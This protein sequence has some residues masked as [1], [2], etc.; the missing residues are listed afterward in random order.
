MRDGLEHQ[1]YLGDGVYAGWDGYHVILWLLEASYLGPHTIALEPLTLAALKLY[2]EE[3][4]PARIREAEA[5]R[6]AQR[7]GD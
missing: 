4:L 7:A 2:V 5:E 3:Y 6:D 1:D